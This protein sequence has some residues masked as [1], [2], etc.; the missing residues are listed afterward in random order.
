MKKRLLS[1]VLLALLCLGLCAPALAYQIYYDNVDEWWGDFGVFYGSEDYPDK[2]YLS[3]Y[4]GPGGDIVIPEG[5]EVIGS[6]LFN[7][8]TAIT[9]VTI[10]DGV[11]AIDGE[12]FQNCVNLTGVTIPDTVTEIG[13]RAFA[14]CEKLTDVTLPEGC[15]VADDAFLGTPYQEALN[16]AL[17]AEKD[18]GAGAPGSILPVI[19]ALVAVAVIAAVI[20]VLKKKKTAGK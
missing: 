15:K 11:T 2:A 13:E 4:R 9:S 10:P 3:A 12:A 5:V 20:L 6:K 17:E 7:D 1:L 18:V 8:P 19:V 16:A 14:S